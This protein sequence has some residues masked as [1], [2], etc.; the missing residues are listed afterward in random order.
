MTCLEQ[1]LAY[2]FLKETL[3]PLEQTVESTE[4]ADQK[5]GATNGT[6]ETSKKE[7]VTQRV[8]DILQHLEKQK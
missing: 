7:Q 5:V 4:E 3:P 1:V 2:L 8:E 6:K